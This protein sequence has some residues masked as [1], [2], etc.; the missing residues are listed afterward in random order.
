[1]NASKAARWSCLLTGAEGVSHAKP[2]L[3]IVPQAL[4]IASLTTPPR[5]S[6]N[7]QASRG[8]HHKFERRRLLIRAMQACTNEL[9]LV[10]TRDACLAS[11]CWFTR[12]SR[13]CPRLLRDGVIQNRF[14]IDDAS[15]QQSLNGIRGCS[16]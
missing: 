7:F 5:D 14:K 12:S 3:G 10:A 2:S 4:R 11:A 13:L 16:D 1:M 15:L 9:F 6:T 8:Y